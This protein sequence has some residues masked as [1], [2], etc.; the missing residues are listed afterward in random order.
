MIG[1]TKS[2]AG[3]A[4]LVKTALAIKHKVLP[5][6]IGVSKPSHVFE[7]KDCPFYVC[8]EPRPWWNGAEPRRAGVSAFGFGG[9]NFHVVVEE[10]Q[11]EY[12]EGGRLD[13]TLRPVEVF[14]WSARQKADL[15]GALAEF[16]RQLSQVKTDDLDQLAF[17]VHVDQQRRRQAG[18]HP[19]CRL[20]MVATSVQDLQDK[21]RHVLAEVP[22][23]AKID[24]PIGVY[25]SEARPIEM[26][27]V[28]F[29]FSG[30]GSQSVNMLR[31]LVLSSPWAF[32]L[33]ERADRQLSEFFESPLSQ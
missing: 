19:G 9:T 2:A 3:L 10:H 29:L 27:Q 20:A 24:N 30:Q 17:S 8:S 26:R 11:G 32:E 15:I 31:D 5:P 4:S 6:T 13:W 22:K 14:C 33:F 12:S 7:Q 21:V 1:H 16:D 18:E 25:Y 23:Q 28:C